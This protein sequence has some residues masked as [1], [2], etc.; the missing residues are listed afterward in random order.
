MLPDF[1]NVDYLLKGSPVQQ[2]GWRILQECNVLQKIEVFQPVLT[3]TLPLDL[4]I[5]GKSDLDIVCE[6]S[7]LSLFAN[8]VRSEFGHHE[9]FEITHKVL[10]ATP[11]IVARFQ[12]AEFFFELFCQV[13]AVEKQYAYRHLCAE[14]IL[15]QR[16]GRAL[17]EQVLALKQSGVKTEPAFAAALGLTGDPYEALL[18]FA[19]EQA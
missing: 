10:R 12:Y 2:R 7:D 8:V 11:S 4:F 13:T 15:L 14:Y 5:A 1:K 18:A 17:K 16:H 3:G 9:A 19:D 6:A